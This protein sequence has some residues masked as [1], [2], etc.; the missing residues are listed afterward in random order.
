MAERSTLKKK[1]ASPDWLVQGVLTKIGDTLDRLTGRGWRPSSSLATSELAERLKSLVDSEL[2]ETPEKRRFVPH[3]IRLKVQWDKFSTDSDTG[4]KKLENELLTALIDHINDRRYHTYGPV[5][6]EVKADYFTS[7]VKLFASFDEATEDEREVSVNVTVPNMTVNLPAELIESQ[8]KPQY[9]LSLLLKFNCGGKDQEKPVE[10]RTGSRTS[11][12]RTKENDIAI[13]NNSVSKMHA[14]LLLNS[15]GDLILADTGSTNGTFI[16][17]ER[18]AYGKANVISGTD[19]L[20]FGTVEV[21]L[22]QFEKNEIVPEVVV[23]QEQ[24]DQ[25]SGS[26]KVGEF[27]FTTKEPAE[28]AEIPALPAATVPSIPVPKSELLKPL[29]KAEPAATEPYID[30]GQK[31]PNEAEEQ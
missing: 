3:N 9:T 11:I 18:I 20:K 12:G 24:P 25:N 13:D 14:S 21:K 16:N 8:V 15:D 26:Y 23:E 1:A 29:L 31:A 28:A 4:L 10:M 5:S 22:D 19:V 2:R 27:E 6:L 30:L 7:G 17:G